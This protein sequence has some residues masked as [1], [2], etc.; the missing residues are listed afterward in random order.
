MSNTIKSSGIDDCPPGEK[1]SSGKKGPIVRMEEHVKRLQ[2]AAGLKGDDIDGMLG[3]K[4]SAAI[5]ERLMGSPEALKSLPADLRES[6]E[7]IEKKLGKGMFEQH[8]KDPGQCV[9]DGS[10]SEGLLHD[11]GTGLLSGTAEPAVI[12]PPPARPPAHAEKAPAEEIIAAPPARPKYNEDGT[13]FGA[14]PAFQ[15]KGLVPFNPEP[16]GGGIIS[17][18]DKAAPSIIDPTIKEAFKGMK[19]Y[20]GTQQGE[21]KTLDQFDSGQ[22]QMKRLDEIKVGPTEYTPVAASQPELLKP[23]NS[24]SLG[25]SAFEGVQHIAHGVSGK[26]KEMFFAADSNTGAPLDNPDPQP[27]ATVAA[28]Y[29]FKP[30]SMSA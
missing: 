30:M 2:E 15:E 5:A 12:A 28:N 19:D 9:V 6:I 1:G 18:P 23:N 4:S 10:A 8:I 22:G 7:A 13:K 11:S 24:A 27:A 25:T 17:A 26:L 21:M 16:S 3:P 14:D 20:I 29:T